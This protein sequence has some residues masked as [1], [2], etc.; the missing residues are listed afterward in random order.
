MKYIKQENTIYEK[1]IDKYM[2]N[3]VEIKKNYNC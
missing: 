3:K 2:I 1:A